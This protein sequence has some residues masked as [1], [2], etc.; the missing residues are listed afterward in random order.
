MWWKYE[1]EGFFGTVL[2]VK[3]K[4]EYT[5]LDCSNFE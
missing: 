1:K 2:L 3:S 4:F 5:L